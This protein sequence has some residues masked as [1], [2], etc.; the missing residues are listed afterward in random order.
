MKKIVIIAIG[1]VAIAVLCVL[2]VKYFDG[3]S[4]ERV[5]MAKAAH[6]ELARMNISSDGREAVVTLAA[7]AATVTFPCPPEMLGGDFIIKLDRKT[8]KVLDVKIW[9]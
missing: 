7:D 6:A 5:E 4:N 3:T 2:G 8:A 9:R 1:V